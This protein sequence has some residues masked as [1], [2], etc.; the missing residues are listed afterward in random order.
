VE[1]IENAPKIGATASFSVPLFLRRRSGGNFAF[2][3]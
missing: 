1:A 3:H 2:H